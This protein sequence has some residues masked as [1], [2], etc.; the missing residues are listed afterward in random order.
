MLNIIRYPAIYTSRKIQKL[1]P[2]SHGVIRLKIRRN[3]LPTE[4]CP[5]EN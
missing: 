2:K 1:P 3:I 4:S 5:P